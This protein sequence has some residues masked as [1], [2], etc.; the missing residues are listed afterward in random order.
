MKRA[1]LVFALT[2]A[3]APAMAS[4][5]SRPEYQAISNYTRHIANINFAEASSSVGLC[6]RKS[7][8]LLVCRV[9]IGGVPRAATGLP[10]VQMTCALGMYAYRSK[11]GHIH[12]DA[13]SGGL[14]NYPAA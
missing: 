2:I 12:V 7:T 5:Q 1:A 4:A 8:R 14:C 13:P 6:H 9:N 10:A 3:M 11:P